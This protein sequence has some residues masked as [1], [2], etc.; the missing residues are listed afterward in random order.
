[1]LLARA[2]ALT[3]A[4]FA[5]AAPSPAAAWHQTAPPGWLTLGFPLPLQTAGD[6]GAEPPGPLMLPVAGAGPVFPEPGGFGGDGGQAVAARISHP[7]QVATLPDGTIV[8]TDSGN[9]RIRSIAPDG[10]I[11]TVAGDGRKCPAPEQPCGDGGPATAAQLNV[12]HDVAA[13]ADGSIL[14]ADTFDN[15]IRRVAPDGT[16]ATVAGTGARCPSGADP[17]GRGGPATA[18]QLALPAGLHPLPSGGFL[19]VDHAT[20]RVRAVHLGTL[21]DLG[22]SGEPGYAGDG[23]PALDA[24]FNAIADAEPLPGGGFLVADGLN[25][26]LRRV[27]GDGTVVPFAGA[28]PAEACGGLDARPA[29]TIRDGGPATDAWIGVPGYMAAASDGSVVY[30]DILDNRIRRIA[31]DGRI[32]TIAGTGEPVTYGGDGGPARD[33]RLAWPSG[34][35]LRAEG[36]VLLT[37]S[38]NNR[39]RLIDD[40]SLRPA[41]LPVSW[42]PG[43]RPLAAIGVSQAPVTRGVARVELTCPVAPGPDPGCEGSVQL[44]ADGAASAPARFMLTSG[45][46]AGLDI[47][48]P[49]ALTDRLAAGPVPALATVLTRQPSGLSGRGSQPLTLVATRTDAPAARRT[50][51]RV[52][53]HVAA[54]RLAGSVRLVVLCDGARP[55]RTRISLRSARRLRCRGLPRMASRRLG[56][57]SVTLPAGRRKAVV[58]RLHRHDLAR[59]ACHRR[60]RAR[61]RAMAGSRTLG[62]RTETLRIG[63]RFRRRYGR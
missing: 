38:G 21:L 30:A 59:L 47:V 15:R 34:V 48:L 51:V 11:A 18:A 31:P 50:T 3:I 46:R 57:A 20:A 58:V 14:I 2:V 28:E 60:V 12:P 45:G 16:I 40:A 24:R 63:P 52:L 36:G 43:V 1:M 42:S 41:A 8:F 54:A 62:A 5:A 23:G 6:E 22:G 13:L 44:A 35:A 32:A 33:A 53:T 61:V 37:D 27:T 49:G 25:C 17:C 9:E 10:K 55:C 7:S 39:I 4:L 29:D 26:R 19:F 56:A